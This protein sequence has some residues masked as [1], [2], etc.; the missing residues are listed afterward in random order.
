MKKILA[1]G[2]VA[3]TLLAGGAMTL[4]LTGDSV[5]EA[6]QTSSQSKRIVDAAKTRGEIGERI[7]GYLAAVTNLSPSVQAAMNDINISRKVVYEQLAEARGQ[8]IRVVA[9]LTG[10]SQIS[11]AAPGEFVQGA[12]GKWVQK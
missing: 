2:L 1:A 10:E 8:S 12:D 11:K 3:A 9:Q 5:A 4:H 6:Q 7:D